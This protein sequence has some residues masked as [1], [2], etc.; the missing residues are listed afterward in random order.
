MDLNELIVFMLQD[1][2]GQNGDA[3]ER[4]YEEIGITAVN[5]G[6]LLQEIVLLAEGLEVG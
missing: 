4:Y 1:K 5:A 2:E 6:V 3:H